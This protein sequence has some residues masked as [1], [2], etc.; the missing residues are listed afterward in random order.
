ME[1][2]AYCPEDTRL[3]IHYARPA[4]QLARYVTAYDVYEARLEVGEEREDVFPPGWAAMRF[5]LKGRDWGVR[6]GRRR[7]DPLPRDALFGPTSHAGLSRFGRGRV[8]SA[9]LTPVG[10][11]RFMRRDASLHADRITDLRQLWPER[12][13]ALRT[14]LESG[15]DPAAVFDDL[16]TRLLGE[17]VPE[18]EAVGRLAAL[19]VEPDLLTTASLAERMGMPARQVAKLSTQHF[20][21]TPKLLLRRA[22]FM[23]ALIEMLRT[24][25][26]GW[27][28]VVARAGYHDQSHFVRDCQLFLGMSMS[29]FIRRPKPLFQASLRLRADVLGAPAQVLHPVAV[30]TSARSGAG[31]DP[32]SSNG[33]PTPSAGRASRRQSGS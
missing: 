4:P 1:G 7:F 27:K 29:A 9:G 24:E 20:G 30:E 5:L 12:A 19:L 28:A 11:A 21:F 10:W 14:A 6:L 15:A 25:R 16:F 31:D 8:A 18:D 3:S 22:R 13:A 32:A 33:T 17:T 2:V 26:G 23:R